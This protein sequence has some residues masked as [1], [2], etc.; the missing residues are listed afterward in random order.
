LYLGRDGRAEDTP[1]AEGLAWSGSHGARR[2][3]RRR[4]EGPRQ[5]S[6]GAWPRQRRS[7]PAARRAP[8]GS[9]RG[10]VRRF[11]TNSAGQ[12]RRAA[13]PRSPRGRASTGGDRMIDTEQ[14]RARLEEERK[15]VQDAIDNIHQE[16]PG[17]LADET[18]EPTFQDNHLGDIATATFDREM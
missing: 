16:N 18:E 13:R 6:A 17:S 8:P 11:G 4:V 3:P 1:A 9:A 7:R 12:D 2:P 15:R 10:G 5:C 14:V